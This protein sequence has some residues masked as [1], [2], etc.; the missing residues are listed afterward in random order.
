M[1]ARRRTARSEP[2]LTTREVVVY[3]AA[4]LIFAALHL[5]FTAVPLSIPLPAGLTFQLAPALVVP[6]FMGLIAGPVAGLWVGLAGR[7]LGDVAVGVGLNGIGLL[8]TGVLGAVA[9][10]GHRPSARFRTVA[11]L[12]RA[13][14]W[15]LL[16]ALAAAVATGLAHYLTTA[17]RDPAAAVD[18]ALSALVTAA[19]TGWLLLPALLVLRGVKRPDPKGL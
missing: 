14:L 18:E 11:G 16:A 17:P 5:V 2:P 13:G 15:V 7:L 9:G 3:T 6:L 1:P 10:L 19:V 8:Y 12:L 4:A